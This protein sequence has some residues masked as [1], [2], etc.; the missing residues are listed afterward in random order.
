M[1]VNHKILFLFATFRGG[2]KWL[3]QPTKIILAHL[4]IYLIIKH[5]IFDS[6][7][8]QKFA[9]IKSRIGGEQYWSGL[10][11]DVIKSTPPTQKN[12]HIQKLKTE[13]FLKISNM[14]I[15]GI[16][17]FQIPKFL[18]LYCL[19]QLSIVGLVC[20]VQN[21]L[22]S[23]LHSSFQRVKGPRRSYKFL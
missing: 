3:P 23:S 12:T 10:K 14:E 8:Y 21:L 19:K 9:I 2:F 16:L 6:N 22:P 18:L 17:R 4:L 20:Q 15:F 1:K 5:T 13:M 7:C 11:L